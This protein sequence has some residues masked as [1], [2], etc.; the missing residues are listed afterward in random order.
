MGA[1][2][3]EPWDND[4]AADWFGDFMERVDVTYIIKTVNR[5]SESEDDYDEIRAVAYILQALGK[6]YIWPIEYADELDNMLIKIIGL[7]ENM[8]KPESEFLD[9]WADS[10]EVIHSVEKQ[11][12]ALKNNQ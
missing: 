11:I 3:F 12:T 1:W 2:G 8:I 5:V 7:L 9:M 4:G 10:D 6:N